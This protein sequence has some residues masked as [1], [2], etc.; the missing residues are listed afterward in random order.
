MMFYRFVSKGVN[1]LVVSGRRNQN[2]VKTSIRRFSACVL[3]KVNKICVHTT[4]NT[5]TIITT[6]YVVNQNVHHSHFA[7]Q[8]A[9]YTHT[10]WLSSKISAQ[11]ETSEFVES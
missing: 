11:Q 6:T 10:G 2:L 7:K 5:N 1:G 4:F 9:S 3:E 8:I